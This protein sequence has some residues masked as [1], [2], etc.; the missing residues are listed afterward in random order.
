MN[1]QKS[2]SKKAQLNKA[3]IVNA[4]KAKIKATEKKE[5]DSLLSKLKTGNDHH[6]NTLKKSIVV[7]QLKSKNLRP[8]AIARL[9]GISQAHIYNM[10]KVNRMPEIVQEF[11]KEGRIGASDALHL[12]RNQANDDSFVETVKSYIIDKESAS[13]Q[14]HDAHMTRK[15]QMMKP[16]KISSDDKNR[17]KEQLEELISAFSPSRISPIKLRLCTNMI[18]QMVFQ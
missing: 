17:L 1:K 8:D 4:Q 10:L 16:K 14:T 18:T 7:A 11:I 13:K 3:K 9:T 6:D 2:V 12:A 15:E 5:I